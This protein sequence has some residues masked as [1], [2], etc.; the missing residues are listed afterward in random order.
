MGMVEFV[1]LAI[2]VCAIAGVSVWLLA[3]F[4]PTHPPLI[5]KLIWGLA[6]FI[7]VLTLIRA[8]G[9]LHY[10]PQIPAVK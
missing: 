5:D 7:I 10:D 9:L 8:T 4:I 1:I 6:I 2:V 3:Y